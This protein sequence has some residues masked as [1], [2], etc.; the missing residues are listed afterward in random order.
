[1]RASALVVGLSCVSIAFSTLDGCSWRKLLP[2]EPSTLPNAVAVD[3]A[4]HLCSLSEG[5]QPFHLILEISAPAG[6]I[7]SAATLPRSS[8]PFARH[9]SPE[10]GPDNMQATVE[11]FWLNAIT[12]RT[13]IQS[14]GFR[15]TRIVN[16]NVVEER[17]IGDYYP[18]WI[19]DFVEGVLNPV[20]EAV[21]L[22]RVPGDIPIGL[23]DEACI[24][25]SGDKPSPDSAQL[26]FRNAEPRIAGVTNARRSLWFDDYAPFGL[27]QIPRTI[28]DNLQPNLLVRGHILQLGPLSRR[29]YPLLKAASFTPPVQR[30]ATAA[31]SPGGALALLQLPGAAWS[32]DSTP[33]SQPTAQAPAS[34]FTQ[35]AE[36]QPSNTQSNVEETP[37]YVRT[38]RTGRVREAYRSPSD[39]YGFEKAALLRA[40]TLRF[41]PLIVNGAARQME[42]LLYLPKTDT[43]NASVA[44]PR[45]TPP[46]TGRSNLGFAYSTHPSH[47]RPASPET[48]TQIPSAAAAP[49]TAGPDQAAAPVP[50]PSDKD[51]E[52]PPAVLAPPEQTHPAPDEPQTPSAP[53]SH[54]IPTT[55]P[56]DAR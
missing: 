32:L 22:R 29:F 27:Q 8:S 45:Q 47:A 7:S 25:T 49:Q 28:V 34:D 44:Q 20:P 12:Y 39:H 41:R 5:D 17:N 43:V 4:L 33:Y 46:L 21:S 6:A 13:E 11:I 3:R 30:L 9:S 24:S 26:C 54:E 38:D 2:A 1:M 55:A 48:H 18:R 14:A 16:G 40:F 52:P 42:A 35:A 36:A 37:I 23:R 50:P 10:S 31:V 19:Q 15:Q 56:P 53:K 51:T